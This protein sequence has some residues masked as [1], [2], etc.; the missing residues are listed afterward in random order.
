MKKL[1]K[2][3]PCPMCGAGET[4][5]DEKHLPPRMSGP[6]ALNQRCDPSLVQRCLD[7]DPRRNLR[8][9]RG[10]RPGSCQRRGRLQSSAAATAKQS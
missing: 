5:I 2:L 9:Q 8:T 7:G 1:M 4:R 6:G 3:M 10:S